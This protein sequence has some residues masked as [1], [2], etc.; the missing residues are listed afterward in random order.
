MRDGNVERA[1]AIYAFIAYNSKLGLGLTDQQIA[2]L[3]QY[4]KSL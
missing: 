4:L 2:D 1:R 3:A